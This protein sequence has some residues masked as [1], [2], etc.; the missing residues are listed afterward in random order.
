[1]HFSV[2]VSC[3]VSLKTEQR[4]Q[5]LCPLT[6]HLHSRGVINHTVQAVGLRPFLSRC[7][8]SQAAG[9]DTHSAAGTIP[10]I[11]IL[12][13]RYYP[14]KVCMGHKDNK[15]ERER[16]THWT[17]CY[18]S[19][20]SQSL[21]RRWV[22][23]GKVWMGE[24]AITQIDSHRIVVIHEESPAAAAAAAHIHQHTHTYC[25]ESEEKLVK[26]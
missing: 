16:H 7:R 5:S 25:S 10:H 19:A 26:Q 1:M 15:S 23:T 20:Q 2:C 8:S 17:S 18:R 14:D 13:C 12:D 3:V 24:M 11:W 9:G 22:L 4:L 21:S 6:I